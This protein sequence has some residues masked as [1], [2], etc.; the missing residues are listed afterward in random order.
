MDF[1]SRAYAQLYDLYRSM[2]PGSRLTAGLLAVVVLLSLGYVFTHQSS[3]PEV[4]LMHGVPVSAS[5]LPQMVAALAKANLKGYVIRGTSILVPHGQEPA[6]MAA[7]ADANAL[8]K[9]SGEARATQSTP[10]AGATTIG[11]ANSGTRSP[12]R[13]AW[14]GSSARCPASSRRPC[15]TTS[16]SSRASTRKK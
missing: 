9:Q 2:T 8:P 11:C 10:A 16:T 1:L 13:R 6:Y 12:C 3:S 4:D 7:L 15:S 5:Q 14:R